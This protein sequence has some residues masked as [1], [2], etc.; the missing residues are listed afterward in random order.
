[1][2]NNAR[3]KPGR[4]N[5]LYYNVGLFVEKLYNEGFFNKQLTYKNS[6]CKTLKKPKVIY[7][8]EPVSNI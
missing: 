8:K 1:M 7:C 3:F 6:F 4:A 5:L 2:K